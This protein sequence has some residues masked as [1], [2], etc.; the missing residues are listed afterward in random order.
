[1]VGEGGPSAVCGFARGGQR[2]VRPWVEMS[3]M[4]HLHPPLATPFIR[5]DRLA[6]AARLAV[7]VL[8]GVGG[9]A[10]L[11]GAATAGQAAA[12]AATGK[13][14][15]APIDTRLNCEVVYL[16]ERSTWTRAVVLTHSGK[17]LRSV[18]IDGVAVYTFALAGPVVLTSLD[19]ER[20]QLDLSQP[21]WTSD[22]RGLASGQGRCELQP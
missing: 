10:G 3:A 18:S 8:V 7:A 22:F 21:A 19:N 1:M 20:I 17:R 6:Q 14:A 5:A 9:A 4:T 15:P 12:S 16:P 13:A 11:A 2:P